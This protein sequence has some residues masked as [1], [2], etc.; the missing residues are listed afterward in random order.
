[1]DNIGIYNPK[2][3]MDAMINAEMSIAE[4]SINKMKKREAIYDTQLQGLQT[5]SGL[6]RRLNDSL[7]K[8]ALAGSIEN[9][10]INS[11]DFDI[12]NPVANSPQAPLG[13]YAIT[14]QQLA[15]AE[16][17]VGTNFFSSKDSALNL[18][19]D[20]IMT[21]NGQTTTVSVSSSDSLEVIAAAINN[22]PANPGITASILAT[23]DHSGAAQYNL[24][25]SSDE[26]GNINAITLNDGTGALGLSSA[27]TTARDAQFTFNGLSVI[28][29][30]NFISDVI[31]G[32][33]FTLIETSTTPITLS[34][35]EDSSTVQSAMNSAINDAV[36]VYNELIDI[37]D[38]NR[39]NP[40]LRDNSFQ[41]VKTELRNMFLTAVN[42]NEVKSLYDLGITYSDSTTEETNN[43]NHATSS[44]L[45]INQYKLSEALAANFNAVSSFF[46]TPNTGFVD[47][48]VGKL[49]TLTTYDGILYSRSMQ[50]NRSKFR[51]ETNI[52]K[53]TKRL[54]LVKNNL[55][56]KY[57][58]L[59]VKIHRFEKISSYLSQQ[60]A[61]L[62][63][64]H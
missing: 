33:S 11:S 57:S 45:V 55:I 53:E 3:D 24:I 60:I 12:I 21:V 51:E 63:R 46:N 54:D 5:L 32:L 39:N 43:G 30:S 29:P 10:R 49:D 20:L 44:K 7:E 23:N 19:G 36:T 35:T 52:S 16:Q 56:K 64:D 18:S 15:V 59:D 47:V 27:T 4:H 25:L 42:A 17:R 14:I 34:V 50:L 9:Y 37:I 6:L 1:M 38:D 62:N 61:A 2:F 28:R 48:A 22:N 26:T 40:Q 58:D 8:I 41:I 13:N 31:S